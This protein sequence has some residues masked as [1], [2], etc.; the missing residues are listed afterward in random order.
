M[1]PHGEMDCCTFNVCFSRFNGC[2]AGSVRGLMRID[3]LGGRFS[4]FK[5]YV[6]SLVLHLEATFIVCQTNF[7]M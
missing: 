1:D 7:G 2:L 4:R 3:P 6:D 5:S